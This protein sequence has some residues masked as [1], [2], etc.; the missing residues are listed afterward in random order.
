MST[1]REGP[2]YTERLTHSSTQKFTENGILLEGF[3]GVGYQLVWSLGVSWQ[4]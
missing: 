1:L 3:V 2:L 4:T